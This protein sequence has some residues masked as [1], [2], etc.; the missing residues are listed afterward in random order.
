MIFKMT[1][2]ASTD[3]AATKAAQKIRRQGFMRGKNMAFAGRGRG[4]WYP[5]VP[6]MLRM[7]FFAHDRV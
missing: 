7:R 6:S 1:Q 3:A 4:E 2:I 5:S